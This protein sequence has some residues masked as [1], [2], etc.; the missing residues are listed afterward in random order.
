MAAAREIGEQYDE[1]LQM[2][3]KAVRE[4]G[5]SEAAHDNLV[6]FHSWKDVLEYANS[7]APL[8][9][10][11][12]MDTRAVRLSP[13]KEQGQEAVYEAHARTIRIWPY[14]STGRGRSRTAD[15]FTADAGHLDRF[16]HSTEGSR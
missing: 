13:R 4:E 11:A 7:G 14:G 6:P 1:E 15:P 12:P 16:L 8:Y 3:A 2:A 9:Y 10:K 5:M